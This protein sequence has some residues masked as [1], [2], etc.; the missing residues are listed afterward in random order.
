V[1]T[2]KPQK[3]ARAKVNVYLAEHLPGLSSAALDGLLHSAEDMG[4]SFDTGQRESRRRT[5]QLGGRRGLVDRCQSCHV[6]TD[7]MMVPP[8][9]C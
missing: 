8:K 5:H 6:G 1:I 4:R 3:T 7:P 9:W 2:T